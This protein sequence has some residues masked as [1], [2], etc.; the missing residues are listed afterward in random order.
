MPPEARGLASCFHHSFSHPS[1]LFAELR[2]FCSDWKKRLKNNEGRL[3]VHLTLPT[4]FFRGNTQGLNGRLGWSGCCSGGSMDTPVVRVLIVD[5]FEEWRR[6]LRAILEE[7]PTLRVAGE[8]A[9]GR[10]ALEQAQVLKPDL[11]LLDVG[12]PVLNGIEVARLI[13][14]SS[15]Q[16]KILFVSENRR[17]EIAEE[18]LRAGA[19]GYVVK[20]HAGTELLPAI[21]AVLQGRQFMSAVL[22][23]LQGF[24]EGT[25]IG[26]NLPHE[27]SVAPFPEPNSA[28]HEVAFYVD[29][30]GL[31]AGFARLSKAVL[32][33][34]GTVLVI[35]TEPHRANICRRLQRDGLDLE[36]EIKTGKFIQ[37]DVAETLQKILEDGHPNALPCA[38]LVSEVVRNARNADRTHRSIA[39]CGE[40]A[41]TLLREGKS[42]AAFRLEH[43]WDEITRAQSTHTLCGYMWNSFPG[44]EL[45][46]VFQRICAE[47]S[48][49]H[50]GN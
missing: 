49:I 5:D 34:E 13:G 35:A 1:R 39:I 23:G 24:S 3:K 45:S 14:N 44:R 50:G 26:G 46:A 25:E 31:E 21:N 41:P 2:L 36:S 4:R 11:V 7:R 32:S 48:A 30:E 12:L 8:A 20:S 16:S 27:K 33:V 19:S 47:H 40:C 38:Q 37:R 29:D 6:A 22:G 17:R 18:G 42:Q 9:N 43:I 28:R 15:R 10:E